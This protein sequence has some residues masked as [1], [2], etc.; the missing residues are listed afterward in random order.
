MLHPIR[1]GL[2]RFPMDIGGW[3]YHEGPRGLP[4]ASARETIALVRTERGGRRGRRGENGQTLELLQR[5][6]ICR[7][8]SP[9]RKQHG[10]MIGAST[11]SYAYPRICGSFFLARALP[12]WPTY[13]PCPLPS[14]PFRQPSRFSRFS[15]PSRFARDHLG[16]K[17]ASRDAP[18]L[19]SPASPVPLP[20]LPLRFRSQVGARAERGNANADPGSCPVVIAVS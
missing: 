3:V 6:N 18:R 14:S 12:S 15:A 17:S 2:T 9:F 1:S 4:E 7:W 11:G 8:R 5:G 19:R 10:G 13:S 16:E 20:V